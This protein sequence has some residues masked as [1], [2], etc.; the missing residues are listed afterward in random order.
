M[1]RHGYQGRKLH[2]DQ[3]QRRA[4][5]RGLAISLI[6]HGSIE[7][8]L[9]KAKELVPFLEV[10]ITKAKAGG[11]HNRR[12]VLSGLDN[13]DA[14]FRLVDELAPKLT[15]RTSGHL[16]IKKSVLRLGDNAQLAV[17]S[18]VDD[19]NAASVTAKPQPVATKE[20]K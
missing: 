15:G 6:E 19:L 2:R 5:L 3:G 17:V 11:L 16:R 13:T 8:T 7:T 10:L 20:A 9:P 14:T 18:F 12:Q 4:L 1:H